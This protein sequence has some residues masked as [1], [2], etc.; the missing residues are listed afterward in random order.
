MINSNLEIPDSDDIIC[1]M[2]DYMKDA[3]NE[4]VMGIID[5]IDDSKTKDFS[6]N[7]YITFLES[8]SKIA[9]SITNVAINAKEAGTRM[10]NRMSLYRYGIESLGFKRI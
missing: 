4:I 5:F 10:E 2:H 1:A 3:S 8:I 6:K 9:N 7:E